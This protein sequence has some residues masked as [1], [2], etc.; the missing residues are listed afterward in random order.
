MVQP[1]AVERKVAELPNG[2]EF[3]LRL[4]SFSNANSAL[5]G[6]IDVRRSDLTA[7]Q[8]SFRDCRSGFAIDSNSRRQNCCSLL[9]SP[10][11]K[12]RILG[13]D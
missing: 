4:T 3:A 10:A 12:S 9:R 6:F 2:I 11:A 13:T 8:R 1:I 5:T 7:N